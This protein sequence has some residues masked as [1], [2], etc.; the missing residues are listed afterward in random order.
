MISGSY[1]VLKVDTRLVA[2]EEIMHSVTDIR[3][4]PLIKTTL[5]GLYT[6]TRPKCQRILYW[7]SDPRRNGQEGQHTI[8]PSML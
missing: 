7:R 3:H 6:P 1:Q 2:R 4:T 8:P 5:I